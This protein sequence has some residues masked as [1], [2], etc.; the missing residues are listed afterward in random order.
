MPTWCLAPSASAS[1]VLEEALLTTVVPL[2]DAAEDAT[3][4][5][6]ALSSAPPQPRPQPK[7]AT[8]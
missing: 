4:Q 2:S 8:A 3:E 6:V 5:Q 1:E 7:W